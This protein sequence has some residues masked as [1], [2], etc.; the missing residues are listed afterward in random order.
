MRQDWIW[1]SIC[2]SGA[3]RPASVTIGCV[4]AL[5]AFAARPAAACSCNRT[6]HVLLPEPF[7][8]DAALWVVGN[9]PEATQ[10]ESLEGTTIG[11]SLGSRLEDSGL[12]GKALTALLPSE[13]LADDAYLLR[14]ATVTVGGVL[15]EGG[16]A[17]LVEPSVRSAPLTIELAVQVQRI[18]E[19]PFVLDGCAAPILL[20][21]IASSSLEVSV[22]ASEPALFVVK[23]SLSDPKAGELSNWQISIDDSGRTPRDSVTFRDAW[24]DGASNCV[25]ITT[26]DL[27]GDQAQ[28]GE[29]CLAI[30]DRA[31]RTQ[32]VELRVAP[33]VPLRLAAGCSIPRPV[34]SSASW[35][36]A[37]LSVL[38]LVR[39]RRL[40]ALL[41]GLLAAGCGD[42]SDAAQESTR[43]TV[44]A[45]E[46]VCDP[47]WIACSTNPW[48]DDLARADNCGQCGKDCGNAACVDGVCQGD[49][50]EVVFQGRAE[51]C[52]LASNGRDLAV[53]DSAGAVTALLDGQP[54][55]LGQGYEFSCEIAI[56]ERFV[57]FQ[58]ALAQL[59]SVGIDGAQATDF[60]LEKHS[61]RS[62]VA[63][64]GGV[65]WLWKDPD[66]RG[67][68]LF[69]LSDGSSLPIVLRHGQMLPLTR[70]G[71]RLCTVVREPLATLECWTKGTRESWLIPALEGTLRLA[72]SGGSGFACSPA[73]LQRFELTNDALPSPAA[74]YCEQIG[75][76]AGAVALLDKHRNIFTLDAAER[77]SRLNAVASRASLFSEEL[78]LHGDRVCWLEGQRVLCARVAL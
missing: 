12:C 78:V 52:G 34:T 24:P 70:D 69:F 1:H 8:G 66:Q 56:N 36:L 22:T 17:A 71:K 38:A 44:P 4:F 60:R 16:S 26:Y 20:D 64:R 28:S 58:S 6:A 2:L 48:C 59:R 50:P 33:A 47:G 32:V 29:Y 49:Q 55:A 65:Y 57:Y 51:L 73:G 31:A 5:A 15:Y 23:S 27:R 11:F 10:I 45:D 39:R 53:A 67:Y 68:D 41:P 77:Q 61:I 19:E 21:R 35:M 54:I 18:A 40:L 74:E 7:P 9:R 37:A 3:V 13:A 14:P 43:F 25:E 42:S 30:G 72:V 76:G 62:L 75:A 63:T 46:L